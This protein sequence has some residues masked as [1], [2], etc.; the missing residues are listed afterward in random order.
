MGGMNHRNKSFVRKFKYRN[1]RYHL[2]LTISVSKTL[3]PDGNGPDQPPEGPVTPIPPGI[4]KPFRTRIRSI[5]FPNGMA[6]T[7]YRHKEVLLDSKTPS[8]AQPEL[9]SVG[10]NKEDSGL[11][12][13][14]NGNAIVIEGKPK[15][16]GTVQIWI[17]F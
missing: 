14:L 10:L 17:E 8:T 13:A 1:N 7:P 2:Y 3:I 16:K 5:H 11:T 12:V 6:G 9:L 4:P 15:E